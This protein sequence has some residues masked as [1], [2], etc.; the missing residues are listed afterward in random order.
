MR[1]NAG[2]V[3]KLPSL[4]AAFSPCLPACPAACLPA[5]PAACLPACL[6]ACPAACPICPQALEHFALAAHLRDPDGLYTLGMCHLRGEGV[7]RNADKALQLLTLAKDSRHLGAAYQVA[8]MHHHGRGAPKNDMHV[9]R[10]G[11]EKRAGGQAR[12]R[13]LSS[14]KWPGCTTAGEEHDSLSGKEYN[15][16]KGGGVGDWGVERG[17]CIICQIF[18]IFHLPRG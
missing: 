14:T 13:A 5:C 18:K 7:K 17:R 4:A 3:L 6:P 10:R 16:W 1:C 9:S 12:F 15:G 8:K 2:K 11:R